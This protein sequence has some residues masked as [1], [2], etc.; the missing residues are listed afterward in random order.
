MR[1]VSNKLILVGIMGSFLFCMIQ[2][3]W[4]GVVDSVSGFF[5]PI[6]CFFLLFQLNMLGAGDIK[7]LAV[8]GGI[9]GTKDMI[10]CL[11]VIF[12]I[13]G[14][15]AFFKMCIQNNLMNRLIYFQHYIV[16]VIQKKR[17]V[18]YIEKEEITEKESMHFTVA[19]WFGVF[20]YSII[21]M[22]VFF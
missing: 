9:L 19:I 17:T 11:C 4:K 16:K 20:F 8:T 18:S 13:G 10:Y 21:S 15:I 12:L 14:V 3:S 7:L 22:D 6:F 1:K 5:L 2:C